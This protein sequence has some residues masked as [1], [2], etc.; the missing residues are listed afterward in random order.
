MRIGLFLDV[1]NT[2]TAGFIQQ[3]FA[4]LL[5]VEPQYIEIENKFQ[6]GTI[7]SFA[8]GEQIIR[9]F[10]EAGFTRE[11]AENHY[12]CVKIAPWAEKILHLPVETYL[13]S[14]G[15]SYFV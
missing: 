11:F 2:L 12:H 1:D 7:S 5:Q 6:N 13:V 3:A 8:F 9:L 4:R 15:P 10:T 14:A